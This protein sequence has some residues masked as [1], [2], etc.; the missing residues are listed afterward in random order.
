MP[1]IVASYALFNELISNFRFGPISDV[2][3]H[4]GSF[5]WSMLAFLRTSTESLPAAIRA[6]AIGGFQMP[7]RLA[8][9]LL[10]RVGDLLIDVSLPRFSSGSASAFHFSRLAQRLLTLRPAYSPSP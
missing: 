3:N 9:D 2:R 4:I 7:F 6:A 5:T 1:T 10:K 8:L